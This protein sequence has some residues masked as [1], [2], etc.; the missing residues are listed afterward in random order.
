MLIEY[1]RSVIPYSL[2]DLQA[3]RY[4]WVLV[5]VCRSCGKLTI[6][7][8]RGTEDEIKSYC[9]N[10]ANAVCDRCLSLLN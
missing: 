8:L 3:G 4:R 5:Y 10:D 7:Y 2:R 9:G 6:D 1:R